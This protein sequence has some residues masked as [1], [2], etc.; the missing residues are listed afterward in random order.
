MS[1]SSAPSFTTWRASSA[2]ISGSVVPMGNPIVLP[3]LTSEPSRVYRARSTYVGFTMTVLNA[4]CLASQHSF[5]MSFFVAVLRM[6][7]LS[8]MLASSCRVSFIFFT[9]LCVGLGCSCGFVAKG[10]LCCLITY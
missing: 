2:L 8:I 9:A 3:I 6:A 1:S 7:V 5:I 4:Y 10:F